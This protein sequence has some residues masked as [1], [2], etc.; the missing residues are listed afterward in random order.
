MAKVLEKQEQ[1]FADPLF[2]KILPALKL[3]YAINLERSLKA[4]GMAADEAARQASL[5]ANNWF[6]GINWEQMGRHRDA[7]NLFRALILAPDWVE[8]NLK[9]G[10]NVAKSLLNPS[11]PQGKAYLSGAAATIG[12]WLAKEVYN[13]QVMGASSLEEGGPQ[14]FNV[15]LGTSAEGNSI[16]G[17]PFGTSAD[18]LR[19]PIE[20]AIQASKGRIDRPLRIIEQRMSVPAAITTRL[21]TNVDERKNPILGRDRFGRDVSIGRQMGNFAEQLPG[22]FT[23]QYLQAWF[24]YLQGESE[25]WEAIFRG[26]ET[27]ISYY[28]L[29]SPEPSVGPPTP[30]RIP[31]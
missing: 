13:Q 23:P 19:L 17:R 10:R 14:P 31:R 5:I 15:K 11:T 28:N 30:P 16:E 29:P 3:E 20:I 24:D 2:K 25:P 12:A 8:T 7:Q 4:N 1:W 27:P 21:V 9:I 26:T 22:G 18:W 6:G